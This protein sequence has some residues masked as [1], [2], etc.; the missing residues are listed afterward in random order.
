M[1]ELTASTDPAPAGQAV[2]G[3]PP[4]ATLY[5]D[6]ANP[7]LL[8]KLPLNAKTLLDTGCATGALGLAYLR[9]NPAARYLGIELNG[10]AAATAA[11]RLT[12]IFTGDAEINPLPFEL[13]DGLD[14]LIYGDVLEHL[15]DPWTLLK[16]QAEALRPGGSAIVCM[17]NMEHWSVVLRLLKGNFDYDNSGILDRTHLRWFTP[18]TMGDALRQAGLELADV[19]PRPV[20]TA[21]A[22]KFTQA[23]AP[24]LAALGIDPAEY[25]NRAAPVQFIW[26]ARKTP[27]PRIFINATMLA[28]LGGVS[29]VR[30]VE[31][32]R[33][34]RTDSAVLTAVTPEPDFGPGMADMPKIAV[35]HRPLLMGE[36][37]LARIR[38]LLAKDYL[39]VTE[40]DDHPVF[41]AN[42]GLDLAQL[43]SFKAVH[44]IQTSTPALAEVLAAENPEI[45][46]FENAI[47]ELPGIRNFANP[48]QITLVFA[49]LNRGD[50][51]A[52]TIPALNDVARA[53][54]RRL[55]FVVAHD[56]DFFDA[57]DT[58]EKEFHP[59]LD[60]PAY[61]NLLANAEI[62]F[63]P[64][65]D[66]VF[67]RAKSDLKFIEAAACRTVSLASPIVYG[68]SIQNQKTGLIFNDLAELRAH[69]LRILAYPEAARR[70]A[71]AARAYVAN[72][73]MLAYQ[74]P[75]RIAWYTDLWSRRDALTAKLRERMP[76]LFP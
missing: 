8:D 45:A 1:N 76:A 25:F 58:S 3:Q 4:G 60:Y 40:F 15:I 64:L 47:F 29:D 65:A 35:L 13:P 67:N 22:N 19:S 42:R 27:P 51:W 36:T 56:K 52:P 34:L 7:E 33:A 38:A 48:D 62:A 17:P 10:A 31:P 53:V 6:Y 28:P 50:D 59:T 46:V 14:C 5:P 63:M 18:R 71:D 37:G 74:L 49:A 11:P 12:D 23:L 75:P 26:R 68:T 61:L 39:I 21:N 57:L 32:Q 73:R 70:I 41:M 66:T 54:G 9:R 44:A 2:A 24:G 69:L 16:R 43:L 30:I 55:K 72:N 20:D